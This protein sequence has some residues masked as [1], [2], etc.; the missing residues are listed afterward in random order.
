VTDAAGHVAGTV[1]AITDHAP[2]ALHQAVTHV[3][4][5][6]QSAPL[7]LPS[8]GLAPVTDTLTDTAGGAVSQLSGTVTGVVQGLSGSTSITGSTSTSG[9]SSSGSLSLGGCLTS[10]LLQN[11]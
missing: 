11:C 7:T 4:Q 10:V 9:G 8:G 6:V 5:V 2:A 3:T 1:D